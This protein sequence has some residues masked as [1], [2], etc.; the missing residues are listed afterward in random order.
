MPSSNNKKVLKLFI[1]CYRFWV[2]DKDFGAAH[3]ILV[4]IHVD[5]AQQ[6]QHPL[7]LG[8]PPAR[9]GLSRQN[10]VPEKWRQWEK[11]LLPTTAQSHSDLIHDESLP[12]H[13]LIEDPSVRKP[14]SPH[15]NVFPQSK[16]LDLMFD[17]ST[18]GMTF[19]NT[20][21]KTVQFDLC[22]WL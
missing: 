1:I 3:L 22:N 14:S 19:I 4:I 7:L 18:R 13:K 6:V 2:L 17:P 9:P 20:C 8:P 11:S 10:G 15:A 16:V 12:Y 21:K 5:R